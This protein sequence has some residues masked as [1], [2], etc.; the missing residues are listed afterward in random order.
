M[1]GLLARSPWVTSPLDHKES[2]VP[3]LTAECPFFFLVE[4]FPLLVLI[5]ALVQLLL[6]DNAWTRATE[7]LGRW[8]GNALAQGFL[9]RSPEKHCRLNILTIANISDRVNIASVWEM[10]SPCLRFTQR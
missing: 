8:M 4:V 2:R 3:S 6:R 9:H 5:V 1:S 7:T 10:D